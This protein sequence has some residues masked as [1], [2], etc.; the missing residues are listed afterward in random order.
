MLKLLFAQEKNFLKCIRL[1]QS[2]RLL[3]EVS[4]TDNQEADIKKIDQ[5]NKEKQSKEERERRKAESKQDK[6]GHQKY[7]KDEERKLS[8]IEHFDEFFEKN[9]LKKDAQ[10]FINAIE[11]FNETNKNRYSIYGYSRRLGILTLPF[12]LG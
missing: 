6:K 2:F 1:N 12:P 11:A 8:L 3:N 10:T 7:Y 5:I 4:K 9:V